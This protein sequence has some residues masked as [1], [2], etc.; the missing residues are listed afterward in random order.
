MRRAT[1][2]IAALSA[3]GTYTNEKTSAET[4][5]GTWNCPLH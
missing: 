1:L 3:D 2:A 4:V 5:I